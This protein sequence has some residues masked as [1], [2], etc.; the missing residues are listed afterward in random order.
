MS[1]GLNYF[2][3]HLGRFSFYKS[4]GI[5]AETSQDYLPK[6][7]DAKSAFLRIKVSL[8]EFLYEF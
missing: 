3:D 2:T 1:R 5:A 6:V 7:P 4:I 8:I